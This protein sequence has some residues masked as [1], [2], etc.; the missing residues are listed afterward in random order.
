MANTT[1]SSIVAVIDRTVTF[2]RS[3]QIPNSDSE[4]ANIEIEDAN[5]R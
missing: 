5:R 1:I 2:L 3:Q 4:D